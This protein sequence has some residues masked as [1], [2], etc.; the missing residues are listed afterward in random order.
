M[1]QTVG[2]VAPQPRLEGKGPGRA[3]RSYSSGWRGRG[4]T[5]QTA[6]ALIPAQQPRR[7][8][9]TGVTR[10]RVEVSEFFLEIGECLGRVRSDLR[11]L[12]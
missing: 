3:V 11:A 1:S 7:S 8:R 12:K 10:F 5:E 9:T 6:M 2:G 4:E